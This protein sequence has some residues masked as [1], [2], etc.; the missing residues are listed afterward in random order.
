MMQWS[1]TAAKQG[2]CMMKSKTILSL[3]GFS[4]VAALTM[5]ARAAPTAPPEAEC[6]EGFTLTSV[7]RAMDQTRAKQVDKDGNQDQY[8]CEKME[9]GKHHYKDNKKKKKPQQ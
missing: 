7:D 8:I 9:A 6:P 3:A 2:K 4:F 1:I 5:T